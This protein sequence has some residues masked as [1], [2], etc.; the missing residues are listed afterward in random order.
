MHLDTA[1]DTAMRRA[2]M[3]QPDED[4]PRLVYADWLDEQGEAALSARAEFIR[5]QCRL[6]LNA[7]SLERRELRDRAIALY[8]AHAHT[9]L[10]KLAEHV[11]YRHF[12]RGFLSDVELNSNQ[13]RRCTD[14]IGRIGPIQRLTVTPRRPLNWLSHCP[15]LS[16]FNVIEV[17]SEEQQ[18]DQSEFDLISD[19]DPTTQI[20]L[21]FLH[22]LAESPYLSSVQ[23]IDSDELNS[24]DQ[25]SIVSLLEKSAGTVNWL[26]QVRFGPNSDLSRLA[27]TPGVGRLRTLSLHQARPKQWAA[28]NNACEPLELNDLSLRE[29]EFKYL[30]RA[31]FRRISG[32]SLSHVVI[33]LDQT[34]IQALRRAEWSKTLESLDLVS[35]PANANIAQLL[36]DAQNFPALRQ[37]HMNG[38]P[39][40]DPNIFAQAH[41]WDVFQ[42]LEWM[43][44]DHPES[45]QE[46]LRRGLTRQM[47][48]LS[49]L[50][51]SL[52]SVK[53]LTAWLNDEEGLPALRELALLGDPTNQPDSPKQVLRL[54]Q[55]LTQAAFTPQLRS[56]EIGYLPLNRKLVRELIDHWPVGSRLEH[57]TIAGTMDFD[58]AALLELLQAEFISGLRSLSVIATGINYKSIC[59]F[60]DCAR[61]A[62]LEV[63]T[64]KTNRFHNCTIQPLFTS[65]RLHHLNTL[66]LNRS[67]LQ[68]ND[69]ALIEQHFSERVEFG[70]GE[71]TFT[72]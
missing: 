52:A 38:F 3:A 37:F 17:S 4:T 28:L 71:A 22:K 65:P 69:I 20:P 15:E 60:A 59:A 26:V 55:K 6:A 32:L 45:F 8:T 10:G 56:L 31:S 40:C 29:S 62:G 1:I 57:L 72:F 41:A 12:H 43:R 33:D 21:R 66:R 5:L 7:S 53:D 42:Q 24:F 18:E 46:S 35:A 2:I 9:W 49:S 11:T 30:A 13:L 14:A 27:Q 34:D 58:D 54:L 51:L 63:L 68:S 39:G 19:S 23:S 70:D 47:K 36:F 25:K 61:L 64:L 48:R 67:D 50:K 16:W 44:I